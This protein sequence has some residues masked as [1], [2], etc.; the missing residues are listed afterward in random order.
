M[1]SGKSKA[2]TPLRIAVVAA[3]VLGTLFW[4]GCLIWWW[5]IPDIRRDGLELLGVFFSTAYFICIALPALVLGLL[6]RWLPV[7]AIFAVLAVALASDALFPW[8]PWQYF[9]GPP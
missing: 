2:W 1:E 7:G 8:I 5:N 9:P 4:L 3:G 6:G